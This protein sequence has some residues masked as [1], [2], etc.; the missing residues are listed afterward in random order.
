MGKHQRSFSFNALTDHFQK[1]EG[2]VIKLI[3]ILRFA[4][5]SHQYCSTF[6]ALKEI[7]LN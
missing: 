4:S 3:R 2:I 7:D 6:N 1:T 5:L